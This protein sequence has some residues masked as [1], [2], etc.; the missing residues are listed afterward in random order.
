MGVFET[1]TQARSWRKFFAGTEQ[2]FKIFI[3][4]VTV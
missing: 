3:S 4:K 1:K 2:N